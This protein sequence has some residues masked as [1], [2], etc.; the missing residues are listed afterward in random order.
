MRLSDRHFGI[1]GD[2]M[3]FMLPPERP[4]ADAKMR[5]FNRDGSEG[6][7]CGNAIRC[8]GK[9]LYEQGLVAKTEMTIETLGGLRQLTLTKTNGEV[10]TVTV[11]MGQPSF[12]CGDVPVNLP[13]KEAVDHPLE[14]GGATYYAT[15]LSM[16]NPHCVVFT[17]DVDILDV[18]HI[19]PLFEHNALFPRRV[20]TE[21]V[22]V[23]NDHSLKMRIWERGNGETQA[24]GTGAC[25]AAVAAVANGHCKKYRISLCGCPAAISSSATPTKGCF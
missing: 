14:I 8:V 3:V 4:E 21:F 23:V 19:G 1:G 18:K 2:G 24:C 7:M 9:Y 17:N 15:C 12:A 20:N 5:I 6:E 22:R 11:N 10:S 13:V 16:G 25:A